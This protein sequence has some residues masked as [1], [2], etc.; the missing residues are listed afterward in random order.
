MN[1]K[2][3]QEKLGATA[4]VLTSMNK[5]EKSEQMYSL[6]GSYFAGSNRT[7]YDPKSK[8]I[9][10]SFSTMAG[11]IH[12]V[13]HGGQIESGKLGYDKT[14]GAPVGHDVFDEKG[15]F[16]VQESLFP[17]SVPDELRDG[18]VNYNS[19]NKIKVNGESIYKS[20]NKTEMNGNTIVNGVKLKDN[21]NNLFI[22]NR[23]KK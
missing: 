4:S 21:P 2:N 12:E 14:T 15:A 8:K 9:T 1:D 5:M 23:K 13:T 7:T 22:D 11:F 18:N 20:I 16:R 19:L 6:S 10:L 3:A 17:N